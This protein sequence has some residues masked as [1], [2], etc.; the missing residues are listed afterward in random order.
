MGPVQTASS[1]APL[2]EDRSAYLL[3]IVPRTPAVLIGLVLIFRILVPLV[4]GLQEHGCCLLYLVAR[5]A[6]LV[7][8]AV[9]VQLV[10]QAQAGQRTQEKTRTR[11]GPAP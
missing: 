3:G 1:A 9:A 4:P 5:D 7:R 10:K 11:A 2:L 8:F 6:I